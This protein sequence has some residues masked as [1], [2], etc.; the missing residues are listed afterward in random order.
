LKFVIEESF[1]NNYLSKI[2]GAI[3]IVTPDSIR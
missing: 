2:G 1:V 3:A